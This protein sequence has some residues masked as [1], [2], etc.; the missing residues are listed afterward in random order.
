M[1]D[2][3]AVDDYLRLRQSLGHEIAEAAWLLPDFVTFM[4]DRGDRP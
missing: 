2:L 4:D 3:A 1:T